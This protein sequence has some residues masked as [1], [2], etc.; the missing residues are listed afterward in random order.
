MYDNNGYYT[1]E[2]KETANNT[3]GAY[4][5][6]QNVNKDAYYQNYNYGSAYGNSYSSNYG[7]SY[8]SY[9][10]KPEKKKTSFCKIIHKNWE[11]GAFAG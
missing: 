9:N 10:K 7:G 6:A 4:S 1:N 2:N 5:G 11:E 3:T 8:N